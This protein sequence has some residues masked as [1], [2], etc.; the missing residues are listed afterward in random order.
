MSAYSSADKTDVL[1][2]GEHSRAV[3]KEG[4]LRNGAF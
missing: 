2:D 1:D 4:G 3:S